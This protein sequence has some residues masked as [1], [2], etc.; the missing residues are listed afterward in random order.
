VNSFS[1]DNQLYLTIRLGQGGF[2]DDRS[3]I[4]K[5][6]G[7]QMAFDIKS[8]SSPFAVSF[9]TE[10]YTNSPDPVHSYEISDMAVLNLLYV[11][12]LFYSKDIYFFSGGGAGWLNVPRDNSKTHRTVR[13]IVY[14]FE[15]G[16]HGRIFWKI[17]L[18]GI[19]KYLYARKKENNVVVIDFNEWIILVGL[20]LYFHF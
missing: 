2:N 11:K 6:G 20:S 9:S 15:T 17:G 12:Q 19:G 18:Y 13:G 5:L 4:G 10:Y 7:G 16:V 3:P 1:K 8:S 14:N